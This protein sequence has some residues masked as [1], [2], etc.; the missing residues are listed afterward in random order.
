MEQIEFWQKVESF[1]NHYELSYAPVRW[2][3][4]WGGFTRGREGYFILFR[5]FF[6]IALY[7]AAFCVLSHSYRGF[8]FHYIY[9][10]PDRLR[11]AIC[12]AL[13][14]FL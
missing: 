13:P 6:L 11:S 7:V 4:A 9:L 14:L 8:S 10:D 1:L 2:F 12:H 3:G 5:F